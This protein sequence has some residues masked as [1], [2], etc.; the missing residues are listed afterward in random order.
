M[1][2]IGNVGLWRIHVSAP[3]LAHHLQDV[4]VIKYLWESNDDVVAFWSVE[5]MCVFVELSAQVKSEAT[6]Q[7]KQLLVEQAG[8]GKQ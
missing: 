6:Q 2:Q 7:V 8:S 5:L 4:W 1:N 3:A